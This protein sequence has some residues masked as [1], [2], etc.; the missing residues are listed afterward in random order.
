MSAQARS[1]PGEILYQFV[2]KSQSIDELFNTLYEHPSELNKQHFMATNEH[3]GKQ[4]RPGQMVIITPPN[5]QLQ[6]C[7]IRY[8]CQLFFKP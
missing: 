1:L 2:T 4:V 8:R 3:L 7:R 6:R 5:A